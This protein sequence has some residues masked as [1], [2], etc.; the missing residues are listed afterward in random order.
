[1]ELYIDSESGDD[2]GDG[3]AEKPLQ[4]VVRALEIADKEADVTLNFAPGK[5]AVPVE[6]GKRVGV[7]AGWIPVIEEEFPPPIVLPINKDAEWINKVTR[8][9][10]MSH[11]VLC[12]ESITEPVG[13]ARN[14]KRPLVE[15]WRSKSVGWRVLLRHNYVNL[16]SSRAWASEKSK[17]YIVQVY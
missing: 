2:G 8:A 4:S 10:D 6:G 14:L 1:M 12:E 17:E 16:A 9:A 13:L 15:E 7:L 11:T 3:S 5:Y